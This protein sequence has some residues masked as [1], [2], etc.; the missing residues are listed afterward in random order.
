MDTSSSVNGQV[1]GSCEGGNGPLSSSQCGE[2]FW[3][4]ADFRRAFCFQRGVGL[5]G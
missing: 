1:V 3:I 4:A 2:I 5:P